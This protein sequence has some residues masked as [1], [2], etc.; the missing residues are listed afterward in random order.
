MKEMFLNIKA[1]IYSFLI[2]VISKRCFVDYM[3]VKILREHDKRIT[4]TL[5]VFG[6]EYVLVFFAGG[7]YRR[8]YVKD[9]DNVNILKTAVYELRKQGYM[10]KGVNG[11]E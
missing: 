6:D 2:R 3:L 8:I 9:L 11:I 7:N 4:S 1:Y 5:L 10:V